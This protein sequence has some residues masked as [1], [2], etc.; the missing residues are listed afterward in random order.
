MQGRNP[1]V[2]RPPHHHVAD[3]DDE[4]IRQY[5]H[6]TPLALPVIHLEP[7]GRVFRAQNRE[8][9][10]IRMGAR[11]Q[12]PR[13]WLARLLGVIENT[14]HAAVFVYLV[15]KVRFRKLERQRED[16][17]DVRRQRLHDAIIFGP[18]FPE[19]PRCFRP[20]GRRKVR[21]AVILLVGGV[22]ARRGE[23]L[24]QVRRRFLVETVRETLVF[25]RDVAV[26]L[27]QHP[28]DFHL[29]RDRQIEKRLRDTVHPIGQVLRDPVA[30]DGEKPDALAGP[31][32]LLGNLMF[33]GRRAFQE[34]SDVDPGNTDAHSRA[35]VRFRFSPARQ[36]ALQS[37]GL[38]GGSVAADPIR[39]AG[40]LA[41]ELSFGVRPHS[42]PARQSAPEKRA[43][44]RHVG[45]RQ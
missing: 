6:V 44:C 27:L 29:L 38:L 43:E 40:K 12:L 23:A 32:D 2:V 17:H 45:R 19:G 37:P 36:Q 26:A 8:G 34:R 25:R 35:S 11:A 41:L 3:I 5:L 4:R 22:D 28:P 39:S 42:R 20:Q 9:A 18:Q 31:P 24:L 1:A 13:Q 14:D 10:V 7:A 30:D 15:R 16:A 21:A 33:A